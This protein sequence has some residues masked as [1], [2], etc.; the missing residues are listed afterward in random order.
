VIDS[1]L[2]AAADKLW[3]SGSHSS[4]L[5]LYQ[6]ICEQAPLDD[7]ALAVYANA[8]ITNRQAFEALNL[9]D[10]IK[11]S[12][13]TASIDLTTIKAKALLAVGDVARSLDLFYRVV[14]R[15]PDWPD[16]LNN[17]ACALVQVGRNVEAIPYLQR[18]VSLDQ[19]HVEAVL[20]LA[21]IYK[22]Q[23]QLD[24]AE[25][26]LTAFLRENENN[27]IRRELIPILLKNGQ[28]SEALRHCQI[29]TSSPG[30][31]FEDNMLEAR[32]LFQ[33]GNVERYIEYLDQHGDKTWKG[34]SLA[35]IAIGTLAESGFKERAAKR[36]EDHLQAHPADANARLVEA[37]ELLRDGDFERGWRSYAHRLRLPANQVHYGLTPTW[38]G[39]SLKGRHVLI[40]GEQGVG[41]ICYFS[42]FIHAVI[43]DAL[44]CSLI[45]EPRMVS[46]L[47]ETFPDLYIFT[48]Q[49]LISRLPTPLC[50]IA[51]GSLPLLYGRSSNE[52]QDHFQPLRVRRSAAECV[53]SRLRADSSH[54]IL[55]GISLSAGRPADEYQQRKRR[56]PTRDVLQQL[57]GLPITLVNLQHNIDP[58][59]IMNLSKQFDLQLLH[60]PELTEN[61]GLLSA[62][63]MSMNLV[64]TAQ[65]T[66]AHLCGALNRSGIVMLPPGC[67]FVYGNQASSIWY[68]SL[69][70]IRSSK[71]GAWQDACASLRP[72]VEMHI[73]NRSN[74]GL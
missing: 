66:N 7:K 20:G 48:D 61:L 41:D 38:A 36:I 37:R 42:R 44:S 11:E 60:Y 19:Y 3:S 51:L 47:E 54:E 46:L 9:L 33:S 12:R 27:I 55:V 5:E 24:A 15:V 8:L 23:S 22:N 70:L 62:A 45:V 39:E 65:Q 34:V 2:A 4:A 40:L 64:V 53:Q 31:S 73:S 74:D 26:L 57:R 10:G 21:R 35:S 16:G 30:S 58:A 25:R 18:A 52:I 14:V 63:I 1:E 72:I 32:A 29:L 13:V 28:T 68:P 50:K 43:A 59:E 49:D 6:H 56:L 67:H 71:W 69:K 17:Y